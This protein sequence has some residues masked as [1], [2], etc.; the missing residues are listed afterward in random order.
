MDDDGISQVAVLIIALLI[1]AYFSAAETAFLN[2]SKSR[3][4]NLAANNRKAAL[5]LKLEDNYDN[6]MS[7]VLIFKIIANITAASL[8]ISIFS[9][10]FINNRIL[11]STV[12]AILIILFSGELIP[13]GLANIAPEKAAMALAPPIRLF[14]Y[15]CTPINFFLSML[16]KMFYKLIKAEELP[17]IT[18]DELRTMIDEVENEGVIN[19]NES[20]L[21][22][23]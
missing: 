9:K 15:I 8:V 3:M 14:I 6:L 7:T 11:L 5:V 13:K 12:I 21:I 1:S 16:K 4:R 17:S 10:I 23:L 20:D 22:N 18:E 2:Y 19:K